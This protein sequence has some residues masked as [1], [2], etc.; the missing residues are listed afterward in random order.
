MKFVG[1]R[2]FNQDVVKYL[3][4]GNEIVVMK[5]K[6]P[7]EWKES[8]GSKKPSARRRGR[9]MDRSSSSWDLRLGRKSTS[10]SKNGSLKNCSKKRE[11]E[12]SFTLSNKRMS[13]N[14]NGPKKDI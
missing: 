1:V 9:S 7:R 10:F 14:R 5:R 8:L 11:N 3:N 13:T 6:K 12:T 4:E 2:E